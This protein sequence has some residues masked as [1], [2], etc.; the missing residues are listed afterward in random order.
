MCTVTYVQLQRTYSAQKIFIPGRRQSKALILLTNI[1]QKSLGDKWQSKTLFLGIFDPHSP[2]VKSAFDCRLLVVI[3][4]GKGLLLQSERVSNNLDPDYAGRFVRPDLEGSSLSTK[5]A[6]SFL[7][8][9]LTLKV[10]VNDFC[11]VT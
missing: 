2:I 11:K 5:L 1:D 4:V 6:V 10:H 8:F 9:R 3:L 7:L